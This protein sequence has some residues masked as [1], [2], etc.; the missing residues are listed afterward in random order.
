MCLEAIT[1]T[2]GNT[3][4]DFAHSNI[5]RLAHALEVSKNEGALKNPTLLER[6]ENGFHGRPVPVALGA[7]KPLG[8]RMFTASYFHGRDGMSGVSFM[9]GDPYPESKSSTLFDVQPAAL[10]APD[11][12]LDILRKHPPNT[13][14]I[15]AVAPLTNLAVAYQKDPATF[16]RVGM[17]SIMGGA[18]DVPGNVRMP[19]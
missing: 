19:Y 7:T 16:R 10:S 18:V 17:I 4:L 9:G 3:T 8:G 1:L 2:F 13:V 6:I 14:R 11:M 5:L 15:A 12:I